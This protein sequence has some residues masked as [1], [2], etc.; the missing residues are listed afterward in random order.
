MK[1]LFNIFIAVAVVTVAMPV[2]A[3][4]RYSCDFEND[5]DRARWVVNPAANENIYNQLKNLWYI[6]EPG[7]NDYNGHYGLYIS[8]DNGQSAHYTNSASCWVFA[9]DTITLNP[10]PNDDYTLSFDYCVMA[11]VASAVDGLYVLWIPTEDFASIGSVPSSTKPAAFANYFLSEQPL[12]AS[13]T[14]N[15][16][17]LKIKGDQCNGKHYL[18]FVWANGSFQAQQPAAKVDNIEI[19]DNMPCD[20]V[21]NLRAKANGTAVDVTWEGSASEYEVSVYSYE[22]NEWNGPKTT[23]EPHAVF[24]DLPIGQTDFIVRAKCED[25]T[26]SL[27]QIVSKL[28]YY[29]DQLCVDYLNLDNA[30]CYIDDYIKEENGEA[31]SGH[32]LDNTLTYN[33]YI[34][35][36]PVDYGPAKKGSRHTVHFDREEY[37]P[38]TGGLAKTVPD[39]ELGS[40]RLGNWNNGRQS[41]RIDFSFEVDTLNFPVLLLKYMPILEAPDHYDQHNPRFKMDILVNGKSVGECAKADFNANDVVEV[42]SAEVG[43]TMRLKAGA[44]EQGWHITEQTV[45]QTHSAVVWKEWTTVGVNLRKPEYVGKKLTA[46]LTTYDCAL[47]EHSGYAYFTLGCSDGKLKGVKCGEINSEFDAPDGFVYRWMYASSEKYRHQANGY[48]PEE[49][50]LGHDQ[51]FVAGY[52]SDS[53]YVVDCMFVQ[54]SSCFFS[55]YASPLANNPIAVMKEPEIQANCTED[56]YVVS[57]DASQSWVQEID[58]VKGITRPSESYHIER[59]EWSIDG[60]SDGWSDQIRPVFSFPGTGGDYKVNLR[61]T[62]GTCDSTIVYDLHLDPFDVYRDTTT[63]VLCDDV[64]RAGY[65]WQENPD[66]LYQ[67]YGL[68]VKARACDS[69]FYLD[70]QEPHRIYVDTVVMQNALPFNYRGRTY[71]ADALDTIPVSDSNCDTTWILNLEVYEPLQASVHDSIFVCAGDPFASLVYDITHGRSLRYSYAFADATFPSIDPIADV[72]K[73]G[74]YEIDIPLPSTIMPN[75]YQGTLLLEDSMPQC[76]VTLPFKLIVQYASSVITQRWNDVLAIRN[77]DYNGGFE[78][79]SVQWYLGNT[80]IDGATDFN[81]YVG[82]GVRLHFGESYSALLTRRDGVKLFT[83]PFTPEPVAAGISDLPTLVPPSAPM[84]IPGKGTAY[85]YDVLGRQYHAQPYN[86]SGIISP[87]VRGY[88]LLVLQADEGRSIHS[89]MVK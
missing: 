58:H 66:T 76:N 23:T 51:H 47:G 39:G 10:M 60:L 4:K 59:Y 45:A 84:Q 13:P 30:V 82:D 21:S 36:K 50:V 29:P 22:T 75:I 31:F 78:F 1:R 27:K 54:D 24:S 57:F 67:T 11:N 77:S 87:A 62:A 19:S 35:V 68:H 79:D 56:R 48:M 12:N 17:V 83:C 6:G 43:N 64:R 52:N 44:A 41:E 55:L 37:E 28:L 63:L 7:N 38:R 8:D 65:V 86:D 33:H 72:Q 5:A 74:H 89:V 40:V 70:L 15:Q 16:C 49:Y 32:E 42:V 53:L 88:Y 85:W 14:W 9:Y 71:T 80:P 81:Y 3:A 20:L 18:V 25:G 69:I 61:V 73:R 46:R 2:Q 26:Y 34:K